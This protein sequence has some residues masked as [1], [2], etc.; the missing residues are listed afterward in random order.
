MSEVD[1]WDQVAE[2]LS[3]LNPFIQYLHATSEG[4]WAVDVVRTK[5]GKNC[6]FGHLI[7]WYYGK[8][9]EGSISRVWDLFEEMWMSTYVIYPIND[10]E[11]PKYQQPTPKQRVIAYMTNLW[12]G[13]EAD[14]QTAM[15]EEAARYA[16]KAPIK[17][18]K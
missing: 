11:N 5:D 14:T 12:L 1:T 18:D 17:A 9:Y 15:A 2:K 8:G 3:D 4:E 6:L 10:G 7:N 13:V 16:L